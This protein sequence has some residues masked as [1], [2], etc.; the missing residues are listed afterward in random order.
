MRPRAADRRFPPIGLTRR[1]PAY[2]AKPDIREAP[3][4]R[5]GSTG[6]ADENATVHREK[7]TQ[8]LPMT[9]NVYEILNCTTQK[10]SRRTV[11]TCR[12]RAGRDSPIRFHLVC[13][14]PARKV[15]AVL[16]SKNNHGYDSENGAYLKASRPTWERSIMASKKISKASR[17]NKRSRGLPIRDSGDSGPGLI[18]PGCARHRPPHWAA[19]GAENSARNC[20]RFHRQ[21]AVEVQ[22]LD[23]LR[24]MNDSGDCA[25]QMIDYFTFRG[26][27]CIVFELLSI[28]LY[29]A[30]KRNNFQGFHLGLVRKFA[31]PI[32]RCLRLLHSQGIVTLRPE[33]V[34]TYIQSR[35]YRAPEVI[36]GMP[37]GPEIDMFSLGCILAE[38]CTA[39]CFR[40]KTNKSSWPAS[41]RSKALPPK[42][43][44]ERSTR[45]NV[46]F[47]AIA[48]DTLTSSKCK[49]RCIRTQRA[50]CS[51]TITKTEDK[52]FPGLGVPRCIETTDASAASEHPWLR[53]SAGRQECVQRLAR[54]GRRCEGF[55]GAP[56]L[57][58][59]C[60]R[61][62]RTREISG[63]ADGL[64]ELPRIS[65]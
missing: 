32:L 62:R 33:A 38:L 50:A 35:F 52:D 10:Q 51:P 16:D 28:N 36:L 31:Q 57:M 37:Y 1:G 64:Q 3:T 6:V 41:W 8:R 12:I 30:E 17:S 14:G 55:E 42:G 63:S 45:S 49:T 4:A 21:A 20:K 22:V 56:N 48:A 27:V 19:C 53:E 25:V 24:R 60:G 59:D 11:S 5:R 65:M 54:N 29:E 2:G 58:E 46:F 23:R 34:Y 7:K 15:E 47:R 39:R 26:H 13:R 43:L 44:L 40:A 61:Q 9:P 18:R